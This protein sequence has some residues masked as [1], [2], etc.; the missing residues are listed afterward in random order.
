M[1]AVHA[2]VRS[3]FGF[4][5]IQSYRG[6][7]GACFGFVLS[8][9]RFVLR[10]YRHDRV[11]AREDP[12]IEH[13]SSMFRRFTDRAFFAHAVNLLHCQC[14]KFTACLKHVVSGEPCKHV[15]CML[16]K[17]SLHSRAAPCAC[18]QSVCGTW[19]PRTSRQAMRATISV[20]RRCGPNVLLR[21]CSTR[22]HLFTQQVSSSLW[23]FR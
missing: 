5:V 3:S 16:D 2:V 22:P 21:V 17:F 4:V 7:V 1:H 19:R 23:T 15:R 9:G 20:R 10:Q 13:T 12:Q 14:S 8:F 11:V 6:I 18:R